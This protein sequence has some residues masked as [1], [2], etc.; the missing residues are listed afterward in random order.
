MIKNTIHINIAIIT[1]AINGLNNKI[2]PK[3][4]SITFSKIEKVWKALF[5]FSAGVTVNILKIAL[6]I[7]H[8]ANK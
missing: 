4:I 1:A 3:T 2:I 5:D 8:I 7:N 6:I